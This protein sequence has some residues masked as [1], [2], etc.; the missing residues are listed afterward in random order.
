MRSWAVSVNPMTRFHRYGMLSLMVGLGLCIGCGARPKAKSS[1]RVL[2]MEPV[3]VEVKE[4]DGKKTVLTYDAQSLFVGAKSAYE[5]GEFKSCVET[6]AQ[7]LSRFPTSRYA[8]VALYNRGLCLEEDRQFSQAALHFR[9]YTAI[10]KNQSDILDGEFRWGF[11]LV[12]SGNYPVAI[13]LYDRLLETP[14]LAGFDRAE[15]FI[16]RGIARMGLKRFATAEKDFQAGLEHVKNQTEG[17]IQGNDLAA[18]SHYRRGELYAVLSGKIRLKLPL[19]TMKTD[20]KAKVRFFRQAQSSF[21]D[22]LNVRSAY[23]ATAAGLKL[24]ELYEHFYDDVIRAEVPKNFDRATQKFY[25]LELKAQLQPI[26]N[27]SVS[28][29]ERNIAMSLRLGTENEWVK[30]TEQRLN[31]L[32][33]LIEEN[34]RAAAAAKP[35]E[36]KPQEQRPRSKRSRL[37]GPGGS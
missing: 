22:T 37:K 8:T 1:S 26:L 27:Q 16:R 17:K 32:R 34:K 11:N 10:A 24:G 33:A 15:C 31:K 36:K 25:L 20:L 13:A 21:V 2:E 5:R 28:I 12:E 3:V 35:M 19:K 18:E 14:A 30:E 9:R 29:Y 7:L 4:Q 23:W 6:Y